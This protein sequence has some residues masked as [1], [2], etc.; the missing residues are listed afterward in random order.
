[1]H[2]LIDEFENLEI[3]VGLGP[4]A[5]TTGT[6]PWAILSKLSLKVHHAGASFAQ[7]GARQVALASGSMPTAVTAITGTP[8][9]STSLQAPFQNRLSLIFAANKH[10]DTNRINIQAQ[11]SSIE[12]VIP[13]RKDRHQTCGAATTQYDRLPVSGGI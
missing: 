5:I 6:A 11:D 13:V 10:R 7:T 2:P 1:L 12:V 8:Y 9:G 3:V 4:P